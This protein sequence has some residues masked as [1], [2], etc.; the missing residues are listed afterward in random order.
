MSQVWGLYV[1]L[2]FKYYFLIHSTSINLLNTGIKWEV[3]YIVS[4]Q[5]ENKFSPVWVF[6]CSKL[7]KQV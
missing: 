4:K 2:Y 1:T 6:E 3:Q 7:V 5:W